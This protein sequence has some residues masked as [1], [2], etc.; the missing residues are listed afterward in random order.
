[1]AR[2]ER[3]E[4]QFDLTH[5]LVDAEAGEF[6]THGAGIEP[7]NI[8][9]RAENLLHRLERGVDIVDQPAVV[10]AALALDQ[11]GDVEPRRIERL[12]DVVARRREEFGLGDIGVVGFALGARQGGIQPREF[13]GALAHA[14]LERFVGAL[15]RFGRLHAGGDVGEGG[16]DAAVRHMVGAHLDH[17]AGLGEALEER[18]AAGDVALDL[19]L[20]EIVDAVGGDVAAPAVEVQD[21]G[22]PAADA[23]QAWRQIEDFAELPVPADQLQVLVEYRDALTHVVERGLQD[24]AV[25][26]NRRVGVV[27]Q[28]QGRLGRNRALAQQQREHQPRGRRPDRRGQDML[29]MTH[30][31]EIGLVI[32]FEADAVRAGEAFERAA[33]A[34]LAEIA[35]DRAGKLLHRHRGAPEPEARRDRRQVR[36]H[37]N[38]G[39]QPLDRRGRAPHGKADVT[40]EIERQAPDHAVHQRRQLEPEQVLRAQHRQSPRPVGED[41]LAEDADVGESRQQQRIGP[42][43]YADAHAGDGAAGGGVPPDQSAEKRRRQLGDCREGENADREQLGIARAAVIHVGEQQDGEDRQP[44]HREQQQADILAAADQR[45]A[46]LQHQRHD[47]VVRHHDRQRHRFHDHHGGGRR[48]TADK[49]GDGENV[50]AGLQRQRQHEHVAVDGAGREYQ[51]AGQSDRYHE[52]VDCHEI[53]R[54]QPGARA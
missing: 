5:Q 44:P 53:E 40:Q 10:A 51:Q 12:Q 6:G 32:G 15:Q 30:Q 2:G 39:L 45:L 52:Q 3:R 9:Q 8:E 28:L 26:L 14:P 33:R 1:M 18:L 35:R 24:F 13:L 23:D 48:Q 17:H 19:R 27:E 21:I 34:F 4:F 31:P 50:G 36:R 42:H 16:D 54:K 22:E 46:P 41:V 38:I 11:A 29:G 47:E 25:V 49:G 7:R 37:K 20:H 43:D